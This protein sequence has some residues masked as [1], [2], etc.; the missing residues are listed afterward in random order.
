MFWY[1]FVFFDPIFFQSF[2]KSFGYFA[3]LGR[4]SWG[5]GGNCP[6][7][8]TLLYPRNSGLLFAAVYKN[9]TLKWSW[10]PKKCVNICNTFEGYY[11]HL[12]F[13]KQNMTTTN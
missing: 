11:T 9:T 8:E 13:Q 12:G 1:F 5:L 2:L 10:D 6:G 7:K 3:L 4:I